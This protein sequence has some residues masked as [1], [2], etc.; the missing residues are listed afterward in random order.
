MKKL[1]DGKLYDT[2]SAEQVAHYSTGGSTS[3]FKYFEETLHRTEAGRW[4]LAG[5]G[6]GMTQYASTTPGGM[7]GWGSDI[8]ALSEDEAYAW[9]E[10]RGYVQK[11]QE[12]FADRIEPA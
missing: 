10:R 5:E 3:D 9:L 11:A 4:F 1:I 8:R 12:H 2:D 6:H 7:K